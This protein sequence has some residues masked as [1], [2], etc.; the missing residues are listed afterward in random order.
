MGIS[1][2]PPAANRRRNNKDTFGAEKVALNDDDLDLDELRQ[3]PEGDWQPEVKLWW[4]VWS[5]SAQ[6]AVFTATD[7]LRLRVLI[8]TVESYYVRPTAQKMAEIRQTEGLL[9]ATYV[10]RMRARMK[11]EKDPPAATA[12]TNLTVIDNYRKKLAG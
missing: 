4:H 8:V 1:G 7:W 5:H 3:I 6:S 9:G 11:V 2:P 12:K 10:D